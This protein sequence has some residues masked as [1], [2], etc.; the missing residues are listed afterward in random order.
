MMKRPGHRTLTIAASA[1]VLCAALPVVALSGSHAQPK[2]VTADDYQRMKFSDS[3]TVDNPWFPLKPGTQLVFVGATSEGKE[4]IPHRVIFTVT[5][6]V[7]VVDG[8]KATVI[9]DRDYADGELVEAEIAFFAQDDLGNVWR[10]G[11]YPEEYEEGKRV[12]AP[13]WIAGKAGAKAGIAMMASPRLGTPDY[14]QGFAPPPVSWTDRGIVYRVNQ[15]TCVPADCFDNVLVTREFN[16]E[17]KGIFQLKF[18][19]RGIGNVR[20]GWQGAKDTNREVLTLWNIVKL[21][22][23]ALKAARAE[24]LKLEANAYK[25][26][27]QIY[28]QTDKATPRGKA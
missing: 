11:E 17:E 22:P 23:A 20:V 13:A 10:L 24:A 2:P 27:K 28:G 16:P 25:T 14:S 18:Y 1:A 12:A 21:G 19:A 4:R 7:K 9:W 5:D 26:K 6:L 3:A 15:R 8:K